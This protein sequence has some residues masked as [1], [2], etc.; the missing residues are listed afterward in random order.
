MNRLR[1]LGAVDL[2]GVSGS[3]LDE[4]LAQPKRVGLLAYLALARPHGYQRTDPLL[5]LFWPDLDAAHAR[6]ALRQSVYFLR[7]HLGAGA[8]LS[9]GRGEELTVSPDL[10]CDAVAFEAAL[11]E[12]R[13]EDALGLYRGPLLDGFH[14]TG[15]GE[16]FEHWL[17]AERQRLELRAERGALELSQTAERDCDRNGALRWARRALALQ[18]L[19]EEAARR[20]I[21]LLDRH[22][23]RA[24]ALHAYEEFAARLEAELGVAPAPETERLAARIRSGESRAGDPGT[25]P[26][27][28]DRSRA[29][30][31][32][33]EPGPRPPETPPADRPDPA[34]KRR[35]SRLVLA[36]LAAV[37][38]GV[39]VFLA[40]RPEGTSPAASPTLAVLPFEVHGADPAWREGMVDLL[41]TRLDGIS[42][43]HTISSRTV[44]A[45]WH[46]RVRDNPTPDLERM[47]AVGR[48][49]DA[50]YALVGSAVGVGPTLRLTAEVYQTADGRA[51]GGAT[52]EGPHDSVLSLV[53]RLSM[54]LLRTLF[55]DTGPE[56]LPV[57]L[58][59]ITTSS[60]PALK[61]YLEGESRFRRSDFEG[62]IQAY[63]QAVA[64]DSTFALAHHRLALSY[65]YVA[66]SL[67]DLPARQSELAARHLDRLPDREALL[68]RTSLAFEQGSIEAIELAR[69]AVD[70]YPED[71]EAW[72]LLGDVTYHLGAPAL[73]AHMA[74]DRALSR[75]VELDSLFLPAYIHLV[76]NAFIL[77]ADSAMA[78]RR[79]AD[80]ARRRGEPEQRVRN[81]LAFDLAFGSPDT[82]RRARGAVGDL[83]PRSARHIALNYL[84][85]PAF[86]EAQAEV[87]RTVR[88]MPG[89]R[90]GLETLFLYFNALGRGRVGEAMGHL[91]DRRM[92]DYRPGA[93]YLGWSTGLPIP[94]PTLDRAL[95]LSAVDTTG[96]YPFFAGARAVDRG[97][98]EE[99]GAARQLLDRLSERAVVEGDPV[100]SRFYAGAAR[101]LEGYAA[102][103]RGDLEA[104]QADLAAARVQAVGR[105]PER[106]MVNST[107]RLWLGRLAYERGQ[108]GEATAYFRSLHEDDMLSSLGALYLAAGYERIGDPGAAQSLRDQ[109]AETWEE[110]DR[111][112]QAWARPGFIPPTLRV[113]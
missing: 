92:D 54:E 15:A 7:R 29:A 90:G 10:W 5:A 60:V 106:W 50:R 13:R 17:D 84:W 49:A 107:V 20:L 109:F 70:L 82:G 41:T 48:A 25:V 87:L 44:F 104:A 96:A 113:R 71:P 34:P 85:H 108:A 4:V 86:L 88:T 1:V 111:Q 46:E 73:V 68:V 53:D 67:S 8:L 42:D 78:R 98:W 99:H 35:V 65:G 47:L 72:Y 37:L 3:T 69:R 43:L 76:H 81:A 77:H 16:E 110:A 61:A 97:R 33:S 74:G 9:R 2:E 21:G 55:R 23:D 32:P 93:A 66:G 38:L 24:G 40:V 105:S 80:F 89:S 36:G 39:V 45:R 12:E 52:V 75:A 22:G 58:A 59:S 100:S 83:S 56:P 63:T 101:G 51:I 31:P 28:G 18:P 14:V 102:W 103:R 79:M 6:A 30:P 95:A 26:A 57:D 91:A 62:A 94:E 27:E 11:D 112:V 19:D 64:E